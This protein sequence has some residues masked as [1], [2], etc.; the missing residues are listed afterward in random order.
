MP[1]CF[2]FDLDG[3]I[4]TEEI[5]PILATELSLEEELHLLTNLTLSGVIPFESSFRL[6]YALL[7]SIPP[8]VIRNL[9]LNVPLNT[10][11]IEF[12]KSNKDRCFIATGNLNVWI[13]P[14]IKKLRCKAFT[15]VA[16]E[17]NKG[18]LSNLEILR[19]NT[20]VLE[21]RKS[22][23]KI[24]VIGESFNDLPMFEAA[25]IGIAFGGV[26]SPVQEVIQSANYVCYEGKTLCR[27]L[28]TL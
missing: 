27:L 6:R 19:K 8:N 11:I 4:T 10:D 23:N 15:S 14:I 16:Q 18:Q 25:D 28:N 17:N 24:V 26:H 2:V 12:I 21:L 7:K 20:A 5:L 9:V 1:T 13:Y 3:T 22:F